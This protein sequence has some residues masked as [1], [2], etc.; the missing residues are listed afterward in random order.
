MPKQGNATRNC[1]AHEITNSKNVTLHG[2]GV[3]TLVH[4]KAKVVMDTLI[5]KLYATIGE[6]NVCTM[7]L[8]NVVK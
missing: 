8:R 3:G 6:M 7:L 1:K 5:L 2:W 4:D